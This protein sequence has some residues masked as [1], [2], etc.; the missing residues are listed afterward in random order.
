MTMLREE[1]KQDD[2]ER[3]NHKHSPR[4]KSNPFTQPNLSKIDQAPLLWRPQ[5]S[6]EQFFYP[7]Q[8]QLPGI[9]QSVQRNLR[10][11]LLTSMNFIGF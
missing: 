1:E 2:N 4:Q 11:P 6:G 5:C 8:S 7:R 10:P 3:V 9:S